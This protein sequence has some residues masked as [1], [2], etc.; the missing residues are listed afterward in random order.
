MNKRIFLALMVAAAFS[1]TAQA[2][3]KINLNKGDKVIET[4]ELGDADYI[5]FGRPD[6]VKAQQSVEIANV[7]AGKNYVNYDV[8]TEK[9]QQPYYQMCVSGSYLNL[10]C[11]QYFGQSFSAMSE[12]DKLQVLATL[13]PQEGY[14]M[15]G[16]ATFKKVDGEMDENSYQT[17]F[18]SADETYYI[19]ACNLVQTEEGYVLGNELSY[20]TVKTAE[21]G[22]SKATLGVEYKGL[23][24]DGKAVFDVTP[25]IDVHSLHLVLATSRSIDEFVNTYGYSALMYTQG[26]N[27]NAEQWQQYGD[28]YKAWNIKKEGDYSFYA[29]GV[30]EKGDWVKASVE[31]V[32]IK[33]LV[34]DDCPEVN[35][36]NN[37]CVDGELA[38]QYEVKSKAEN[39][40]SAKMLIMKEAE[41]DNTLNDMVRETGAEKPSELWADYMSTTDKA[42]D[43]TEALKALGNTFTF[44]KSFT[45]EE[46]GWYVA[47]LAVTD[48]YGTTVTRASFHTHLDNAE[49]DIISNTYPLKNNLST[50]V[51]AKNVLAEKAFDKVKLPIAGLPIKKGL[52]KMNKGANDKLIIMGR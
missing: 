19:V 29:L 5:A 43:V 32:H 31:K 28:Q 38:I 18:I 20:Q 2:Q 45:Q 7:K 46:R 48:D 8:V 6:G 30:D 17:I 15:M 50:K 21:A 3:Q 24:A 36:V 13:L 47:V 1:A 49:W 51:S 16:N 4:V 42:E 11:I 33:P 41:W 27:F 23:D 37:Q 44:K 39:I 34:T 40:K 26:I 12:S 52:V 10:F 25:G 14:G 9:E 35:I 22:E